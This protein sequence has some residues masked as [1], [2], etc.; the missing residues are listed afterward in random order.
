[1]CWRSTPPAALSGNPLGESG[2]ANS[3]ATHV[4][5]PRAVSKPKPLQLG[6]HCLH[7]LDAWAARFEP[8]P[9]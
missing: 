7:Q 2:A 4:L 3:T 6:S 1:M 5:Q 8:A 9:C